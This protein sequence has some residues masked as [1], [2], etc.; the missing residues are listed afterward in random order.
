MLYFWSNSNV[1]ILWNICLG[2]DPQVSYEGQAHKKSALLSYLRPRIA[3]TASEVTSMVALLIFF[4]LVSFNYLRFE[5][6]KIFQ[7]RSKVCLIYDVY[8]MSRS[9]VA[10]GTS[11]KI[12]F[13]P[14][15]QGYDS[16]N[17][18]GFESSKKFFERSKKT[19]K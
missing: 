7:K 2:L 1:Y 17:Y 8:V 5:F 12:Y 18:A 3:S 9:R 14:M 16:R 6:K 19:M 11:L 10:S 4:A 13:R 15:I